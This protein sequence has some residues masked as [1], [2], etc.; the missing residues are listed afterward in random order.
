[1]ENKYYKFLKETE[2]F[3]GDSYTKSGC[4]E[5][6]CTDNVMHI[7][8][9]LNIGNTCNLNLKQFGWLETYFNI[10]IVEITPYH[11]RISILYENNIDDHLHEATFRKLKNEGFVKS[12]LQIALGRELS[13]CC[14]M[15]QV[16]LFMFFDRE[17]YI[18]H[19]SKN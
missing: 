18:E 13:T 2:S 9:P 3:Y 1:M 19:L 12:E 17:G 11:N 6:G 16:V 4:I 8:C 5:S 7:F 14:D 15:I 10:S